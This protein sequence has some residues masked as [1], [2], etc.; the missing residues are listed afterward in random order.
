MENLFSFSFEFCYVASLEELQKHN[1]QKLFHNFSRAVFVD[2]FSVYN[3][4]LLKIVSYS[5]LYK[6]LKKF[7]VE[8]LILNVLNMTNLLFRQISDFS[9]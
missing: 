6:F 1:L 9:C 3:F 4:L 7:Q 5:E 8:I 2:S